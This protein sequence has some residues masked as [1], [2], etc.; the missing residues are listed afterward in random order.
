MFTAGQLA[1]LTAICAVL[2]GAKI[3]TWEIII[4]AITGFVFAGLAHLQARTLEFLVAPRH[5][6]I[7][8]PG[9]EN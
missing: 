7:N 3:Y 9:D 5:A 6:R 4:M 2:A 8:C 1:F